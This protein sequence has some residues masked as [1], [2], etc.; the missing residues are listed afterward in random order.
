MTYETHLD[1]QLRNVPIYAL[2]AENAVSKELT[3]GS[4]PETTILRL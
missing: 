4:L 1:L 3:N 2:G